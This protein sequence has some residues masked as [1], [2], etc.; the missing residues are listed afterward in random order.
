MMMKHYLFID[1]VLNLPELSTVVTGLLG[2]PHE[3][4]D[5]NRYYDIGKLGSVVI[6]DAADDP[7]D[8]QDDE[9][10]YVIEVSESD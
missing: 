5:G 9:Y 8:S 3:S 1:G 4:S 10:R 6:K 7:N 2:Q